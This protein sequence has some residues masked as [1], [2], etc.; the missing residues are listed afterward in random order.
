MN[1]YY[2]WSDGDYEDFIKQLSTFI[3]TTGLAVVL[4]G[5]RDL[6]IHNKNLPGSHKNHILKISSISEVE[7]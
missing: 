3:A 5:E 7:K 2:D 4:N 1:F 6:F